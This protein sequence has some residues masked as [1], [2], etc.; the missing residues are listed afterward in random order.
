M[1]I[2]V[3]VVIEAD[4]EAAGNA[5]ELACFEREALTQANLGLTLSESKAVLSA[6]QAHLVAQQVD[7]YL[8]E[9]AR[10]PHCGLVRARKGQHQLTMRTLF[11]TLKLESPRFYTCACLPTERQSFS[12]LA[13]LLPERGTPER[14][15]L[16][17]KWA[18]LMSY[19]LTVDRLSEVLP[20]EVDET[21]LKRHIIALAERCE[22]ALGDEQ[23]SFIDG[24]QREWNDLPIPDAPL[25]V[26]LDGGYLQARLGDNRMAGSFEVIV[27][28][29]LSEERA[30]K[31]FGFVNGFDDKPR[32]R[33]FE[34]LKAQGLQMN[35]PITFLSDGGDT[36]RD[37]QFYLSPQSEH[38][39][40]WFH[41]TMRL[42]VIQQLVK[43]VSAA[44]L[45][46]DDRPLDAAHE[47][48]RVKWFVWHGNVFKT[49]QTL[50][51]LE[52]D[53]ED[54]DSEGECPE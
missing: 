11:G 38:L 5:T 25:T 19:G 21:S 46:L 3:Q 18:A 54:L 50:D 6:L 4:D 51:D 17:T 30:D 31:C 42:T 12:P 36:V 41:I 34:T 37:L 10:C 9:Q 20:L 26:G 52:S 24:Y 2:K 23:A 47:L 44:L 1:R 39:L 13:E 48:E 15:Y 27:G 28:K 22:Q 32:R 7:A 53:L 40:D 14:L 45:Q 33:L 8:T 29:S 35:Q 49:L 43:G 16:Q